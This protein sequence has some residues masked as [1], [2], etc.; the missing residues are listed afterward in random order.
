MSEAIDRLKIRGRPK[1]GPND[2]VPEDKL[3]VAFDTD[4]IEPVSGE[5]IPERIRF[6]DFSCNWS[7]FSKPAD[8]R[9]RPNGQAGD[10]CYS[11]TVAVARYKELATTVHDPISKANYENYAH[12]EVREL[13]HG[14]SVYSEPPRGRKSSSKG[15]KN[16]RIEYRQNI[17][18]NRAI[19]LEIG[20]NA[21]PFA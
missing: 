11:F 2:F 15:R 10:G 7:R 3:Y 1:L 19:E 21:A 18:N 12:V 14:E 9:L 20:E 16:L 8:V 4:D 17:I 5:L 6:P 13:R